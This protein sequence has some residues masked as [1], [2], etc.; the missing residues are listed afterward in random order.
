[1][2][3]QDY[4]PVFVETYKGYEIFQIPTS[5][6]DRHVAYKRND[7]NPAARSKELK[8]IRGVLDVLAEEAARKDFP[9]GCWNC[10]NHL[11]GGACRLNLEPD[12]GEGGYEAWEQ[13][14]SPS[15]IIAEV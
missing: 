1:M 4:Q 10:G 8:E 15:A 7:I 3:Q 12:C 11:G 5:A 14:G 6:G 13:V 2:E 9:K